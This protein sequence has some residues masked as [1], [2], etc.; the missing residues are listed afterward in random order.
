MNRTRFPEKFASNVDRKRFW[1]QHV[2]GWRK[3]GLSQKE[4]GRRHHINDRSLGYWSGRL[5]REVKN[6][7]KPTGKPSQESVFAES[8]SSPLPVSAVKRLKPERDV[9]THD[10]GTLVQVFPHFDNLRAIESRR[11]SGL[12]IHVLS[13]RFQVEVRD[14][15]VLSLLPKVLCTLE[16]QGPGQT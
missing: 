14:G 10:S 13:G 9:L 8:F 6:P 4:Y 11:P 1:R 7:E 16:A 12:L 3:S 15:S 2:L 5:N